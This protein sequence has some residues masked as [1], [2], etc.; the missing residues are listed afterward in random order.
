MILSKKPRVEKNKREKILEILQ[1]AEMYGVLLTSLWPLV[2]VKKVCV[3]CTPSSAR[4]FC[5]N[6]RFVFSLPQK[7]LQLMIELMANLRFDHSN[8]GVAA[9]HRYTNKKQVM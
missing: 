3:I 8:Y 4:H 6:C 2:V 9:Q 1:Q 7:I 5:L